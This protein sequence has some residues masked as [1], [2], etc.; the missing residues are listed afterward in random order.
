MNVIISAEEYVPLPAWKLDTSDSRLHSLKRPMTPPAGIVRSPAEFE[1]MKGFLVSW[2]TLDSHMEDIYLTFV[3]QIADPNTLF[4][5]VNSAS[6]QSQITNIILYAGSDLSNVTF[7]L[8]ESESCWMRDYGP[9]FIYEDGEPAIVD[10]DYYPERPLGDAFPANL[11]SLCRMDSYEMSLSWE[12][13]NFMSDGMGLC[14]SS[15]R[16]LTDNSYYS[17]S[18]IAAMM[19]DYFGCERFHFMEE[20]TYD[21]TGHIDM[22]SKLIDPYRVIV[23]ETDA[24]GDAT[25]LDR[26]ASAFDT[27]TTSDGTTTLEV[28]RIPL[29]REFDWWTFSYVYFTYTNSLIVD[30]QVFVPTYG[31]PQDTEALG[32]YETLLPGY[33]I[34]PVD[35]SP[36]ID[37]GGAVHCITHEWPATYPLNI[38]EIPIPELSISAYP[39]PFNSSTLVDVRTDADNAR[40]R[41]IDLNGREV[42]SQLLDRG[43]CI[44]SFSDDIPAGTYYA[45]VS[46]GISTKSVKLIYVK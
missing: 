39:N 20:M 14:F 23:S 18:E 29:K 16:I 38:S 19:E 12:G 42:F 1:D 37:L 8:I 2:N 13:G 11:A 30:N 17:E 45:Q 10:L 31:I 34:V 43:E 27:I 32:V 6:Q 7:L 33:D 3:E 15:T 21:G 36:I 24:S 40:L 44:L 9:Y 35:C 4:V 28:F 26:V 22:Y 46:A 5:A 41:I 25:I